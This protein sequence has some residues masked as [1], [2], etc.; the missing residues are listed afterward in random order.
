MRLHYTLLTL[1]LCAAELLAAAPALAVTAP[2]P[3]RISA[4]KATAVA[5][6]EVEGIL[7]FRLPNGLQVLLMPDAS[8]PTIT[9][10]VTYRVGSRH[11]GSGETGMAHLLEHLMF[12]STP[13]YAN[14]GAELSRRG[15]RFN[16]STNADRTNYFETFPADPAQLA[17]VLKTEAERMTGAKVLRSDLDSEMTVV[18]NEMESGENSPVRILMEKTEAAAYQW[19]AYGRSTIGARSDVEN[20]DIPRL[21]AFYRQYYQPDNATLIVAGAFDASTTLAQITRQFGRLPKPA[22]VLQPTYTV[23]PVQDGERLVTL[24]RTGG[25]QAL[26]A[27]YHVPALASRDFAGFEIIANALSDSSSGRL[28][29]RLVEAGKATGAFGNVTHNAEPGLFAVGVQLKKDDALDEAQKILLDS[30]EGLAAEPITAEEL[31]R[32]QVQWAN[33]FDKM[34]A[35]P[36]GLCVALSEPIAAGDWRLLFQLRDR[37]QNITLDEVNAVARSWLKPSNRTLGRFIATD[38][39]D[40]SPLAAKVDAQQALQDFKPRAAVAA[41][42][43]FDPS[44]ANLD[45]RTERYTLPSGLK[46]ALLP[47]KSRGQTVEVALALHFGTPDSLRGRSAAADAAGELL[48]TGTLTKTRAQISDAFDALKTDWSVGGSALGGSAALSTKRDSVAPALTLLA[49]VLRQPSFPP[50]EFEQYIRQSLGGLERAAD[51]PRTVAS[52]ALSRALYDYPADDVRHVATLAESVAELKRLKL[53][54]AVAFYRSHWGAS[55]GEISL[56]GDFDPAQVKPLIAQLLG[57]WTSPQAYA[58]ITMPASRTSGQKLLSSLQDKQNAVVLGSLPLQLADTDADY[59]ALSLAVQVLGAGGFDSR[60]IARLRQKDG[61]SYSAGASLSA[62]S[63]EPAGSL[64]FSAIFAP[65]NRARVEQGFAEELER[66]VKDGI[67]ADEL[68]NARKAIL[69]GNRTRRAND[70]AVARGWTARLERDRSFQRDS[71]LEARLSGLTVDQVNAAIRKW[72]RPGDV[73]WSLAG[74]FATAP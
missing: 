51:D 40:R 38:S 48:G 44:P 67:T 66:F 63:F 25:L 60:L 59:P 17:W 61:L 31:Q 68:A 13:S 29:R 23:E 47:K 26:Y 74:S 56:V 64:S 50:A 37:I 33:D 28:H 14:V 55:H 49:E 72:I 8:Q 69:A 12:K 10:N 21:Q 34:L 36:Q 30:I 22:R 70:G 58:R 18:R 52:L 43:A 41:G 6:R 46:V 32:T 1:S 11:E 54:E 35:N 45:A 71:E 39:P 2:P 7:E 19:H 24:R 5:V 65:Q 27:V 20:V 9:V 73:N 15:M 57:D 16:G 62:S 53:E 3:A 4:L 42:E